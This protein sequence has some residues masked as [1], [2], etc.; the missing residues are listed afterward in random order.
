LPKVHNDAP[1]FACGPRERFAARRCAF[2]QS[3]TSARR[4]SVNR[5]PRLGLLIQFAL[6][7][8]KKGVKLLEPRG[9]YINGYD[10][11]LSR[12][13]TLLSSAREASAW[14]YRS[15]VPV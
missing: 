12:R 9:V 6:V 4:R 8:G 13:A 11:L 2:F 14:R 10:W 5:I 7:L 1:G 15:L 3:L